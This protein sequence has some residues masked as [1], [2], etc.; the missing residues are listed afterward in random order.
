MANRPQRKSTAF[1][2]DI[3]V[4]KLIL[5]FLLVPLLSGCEELALRLYFDEE[6]GVW[7]LNPIEPEVLSC[8]FVHSEWGTYGVRDGNGAVAFYEWGTITR[9]QWHTLSELEAARVTPYSEIE[10]SLGATN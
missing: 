1:Y 5:A 8:E 9:D 2:G 6:S 7:G 10:I 4:N 3:S